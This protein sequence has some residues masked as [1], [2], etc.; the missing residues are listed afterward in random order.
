MIDFKKYGYQ[1]ILEGLINNN[2]PSYFVMPKAYLLRKNNN[3]YWLQYDESLYLDLSSMGVK[4]DEQ[5]I[6]DM[7]VPYDKKYDRNLDS[8][9]DQTYENK[10]K[11]RESKL[12]TLLD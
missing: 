9:K 11:Y 1:V 5:N 8:L 10:M 6:I 4:L 12:S 7:I 2:N 3:D